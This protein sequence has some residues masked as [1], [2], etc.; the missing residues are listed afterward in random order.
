[1]KLLCCEKAI[2]EKWRGDNGLD[3]VDFKNNVLALCTQSHK[4]QNSGY[5]AQYFYT[6]LR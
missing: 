5:L 6:F 2:C 4:L 3:V 1:M